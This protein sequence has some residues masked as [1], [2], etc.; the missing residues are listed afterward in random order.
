MPTAVADP[1]HDVCS[2][3]VIEERSIFQ[4]RLVSDGIA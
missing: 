1:N 3:I 2:I 4:V